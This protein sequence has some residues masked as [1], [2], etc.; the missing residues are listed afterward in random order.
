MTFSTSE[1]L[2]MEEPLAELERHLI[3]AY[4]AG[5]GYTIHDLMRRDDEAARRLLAH[6]STYASDRLAEIE[7][8][9]HYFR[10]LHGSE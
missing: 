9:S 1:R 5:A 4:L 7:A 2:P 3:D 8:R 6:A 10:R